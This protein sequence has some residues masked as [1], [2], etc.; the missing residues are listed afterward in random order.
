VQSLVDRWGPG[1]NWQNV[2]EPQP[3]EAGHLR[4][5]CSKAREMLGWAPRWSLETAL[6]R[7]LSWH[8]AQLSGAD[9]RAVTLSQIEAYEKHEPPT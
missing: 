1:A 6:E 7:V 9:M 4:L 8:L 3:H 5:D 2:A